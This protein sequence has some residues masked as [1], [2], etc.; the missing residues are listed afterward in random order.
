MPFPGNEPCT[1][2]R[3][4]AQLFVAQFLT[5][6]LVILRFVHERD[7]VGLQVG[8]WQKTLK[9]H[10]NYASNGFHLKLYIGIILT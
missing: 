8:F 10:K 9:S 4:A 3:Y 7:A 6:E 5:A 2:T 1:P